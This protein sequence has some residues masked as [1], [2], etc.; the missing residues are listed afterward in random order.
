MYEL[1]MLTRP[2][3]NASIFQLAQLVVRGDLPVLTDQAKLRYPLLLPIWMECV[4][5]DPSLRPSLERIRV[6]MQRVLM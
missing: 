3:S 2:Y 5:T 1:M 4:T 6:E